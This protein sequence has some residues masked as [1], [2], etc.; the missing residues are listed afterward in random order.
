MKRLIAPFVIGL[1]MAG[2]FAF[3]GVTKPETIVN[4]LDFFGNWDGSV[5]AVMGAAVTVTFILF[6]VILRARKQP[7]FEAKFGIPTRR[8]I[9]WRLMVGASAFGLG[10]GLIGFC[11]GP[12]IASLATGS[13]EL[14]VW[15]VGLLAGMY[16]FKGFERV[17][18]ARSAKREITA[19]RVGRQ[20][21][22][23]SA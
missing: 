12:A 19:K 20:T 7:M 17:L 18:Q 6:R 15:F 4:F 10:W 16:I 3:A 13:T 14:Y 21:A 22:S 1:V 2:G 11:P 9:D 8:D 5:M 23:A